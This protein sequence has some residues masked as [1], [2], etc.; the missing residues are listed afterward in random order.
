MSSSRIWCNRVAV[1][2]VF[3]ESIEP[4]NLVTTVSL[5]FNV[6]AV[7]ILSR[8]SPSERR[9]VFYGFVIYVPVYSI[10]LV[11]LVSTLR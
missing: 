5:M 11:F 2:V 1:V 8:S 7:T 3:S 4:N 6:C 9:N 10:R